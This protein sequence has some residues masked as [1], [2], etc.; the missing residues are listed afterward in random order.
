[1]ASQLVYVGNALVW[2]FTA[3][4]PVVMRYMNT[5]ERNAVTAWQA[6]TLPIR[7][8]FHPG[9]ATG[10]PIYIRVDG[11]TD[12]SNVP[13]VDTKTGSATDFGKNLESLSNYQKLVGG[14]LQGKKYGAALGQGS[15][16]ALRV[17][18]NTQFNN[19]QLIAHRY[20][21][22]EDPP[23]DPVATAATRG[24]AATANCTGQV[25]NTK[26]KNACPVCFQYS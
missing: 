2:K 12:N 15:A 11:A 23:P 17:L 13:K 1:M 6:A 9:H 22:N 26:G 7:F 16:T 10:E 19:L 5:Q 3:T 14:V 21:N 8:E 18:L 24:C 4:D 25:Q 20:W